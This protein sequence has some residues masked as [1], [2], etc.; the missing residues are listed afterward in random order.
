MHR[1]QPSSPRLSVSRSIIA[2]RHDSAYAG[3]GTFIG[4][5]ETAYLH[6]RRNAL[7]NAIDILKNSSTGR[8]TRVA[9]VATLLV[10]PFSRVHRRGFHGVVRLHT[11]QRTVLKHYV[12]VASAAN[13]RGRDVDKSDFTSRQLFCFARS[14]MRTRF[15]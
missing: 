8:T 5:E 13:D 3:L 12:P 9:N 6:G 10:R 7:K 1:A 11:T 14:T 2:V 15:E 4:D